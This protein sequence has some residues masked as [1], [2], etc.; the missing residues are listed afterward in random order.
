MNNSLINISGKLPTNLDDPDEVPV[1]SKRDFTKFT[2][3][4]PRLW[5]SITKLVS[6]KCA[7][8]G[9][10]QVPAKELF[11]LLQETGRHEISRLQDDN[12]WLATEIFRHLLRS[13]TEK[14][15]ATNEE[16][17]S[18]MLIG[19][20]DL[21]VLHDKTG[22]SSWPDSEYP[23]RLSCDGLV[24]KMQVSCRSCSFWR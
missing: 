11:Y 10:F 22:D 21:K 2:T 13:I 8:C 3:L 14:V 15:K 23:L 19:S 5:D 12:E 1:I 6:V 16:W 24:F 9:S 17:Y 4:C 18:Y 20:P 7:S